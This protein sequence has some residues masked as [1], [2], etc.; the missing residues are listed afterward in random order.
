M[1]QPMGMLWSVSNW[2]LHSRKRTVKVYV[3]V[4]DLTR[5][6]KKG[7][8][9]LIQFLISKLRMQKTDMHIIGDICWW[10]MLMMRSR[11]EIGVV[12]S[13]CDFNDLPWVTKEVA[14]CCCFNQSKDN[15]FDISR[16]KIY[17]VL[18]TKS[19]KLFH[20]SNLLILG[21]LVF[22]KGR[23]GLLKHTFQMN[24]VLL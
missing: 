22:A 12:E 3:R 9:T 15:V 20:K 13:G 5:F 11:R 18:L 6:Q 4:Y 2:Y 16:H 10:N 1:S 24:L 17:P 7:S 19:F 8:Q 21:I 14:L 23:S